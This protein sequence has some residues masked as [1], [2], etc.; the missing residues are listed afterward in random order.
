MPSEEQ[1][2]VVKEVVVLGIE[3]FEK[4]LQN[5]HSS[6]GAEALDRFAERTRQF[7][8]KGVQRE[9]WIAAEL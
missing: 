8:Q 3:G 9:L 7:G 4:A 6:F 2:V 1:L 5:S